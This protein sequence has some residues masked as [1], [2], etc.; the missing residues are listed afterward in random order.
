[1]LRDLKAFSS[2]L[3]S[4]KSKAKEESVVML[5][6]LKHV[7]E[8]DIQTF[9]QSFA[10]K[11][12]Q[13]NIDFLFRYPVQWKQINIEAAYK[14]KMEFDEVEHE[15]ILRGIRVSKSHKQGSEFFTYQLDFEKEFDS[16]ED[17][18][19]I[20]YLNQKE[21][22]ETGKKKFIEYSTYLTPLEAL[23]KP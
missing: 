22:D 11:C 3:V 15:C 20:S 13:E 18:L 12:K 23:M 8:G 9:L 5:F 16:R 2:K 19:F 10:D 4:V 1:M 21:M 14:F 6:T 7:A 17:Q